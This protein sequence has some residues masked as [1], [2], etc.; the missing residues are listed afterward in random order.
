M[1]LSGYDRKKRRKNRDK[2]TLVTAVSH[3][4]VGHASACA[5][6]KFC[7]LFTHPTCILHF[8]AISSPFSSIKIG[9]LVVYM[10]YLIL[11][12]KTK[13]I[14]YEKGKFLKI[15]VTSKAKNYVNWAL[16]DFFLSYLIKTKYSH[17]PANDT[18]PPNDTLL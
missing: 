7:H 10:T 3:W 11:R 2:Q 15:S 13:P 4:I 18:P 5:V 9:I 17:P 16:C 1:K 12:K 8:I 6:F 14:S